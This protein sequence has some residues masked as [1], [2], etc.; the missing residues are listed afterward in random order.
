LPH[1]SIVPIVAQSCELLQVSWRYKKSSWSDTTVT[2]DKAEYIDQF[3]EEEGDVCAN[4]FFGIATT[5][6]SLQRIVLLLKQLNEN[7]TATNKANISTAHNNSIINI[8]AK[9]NR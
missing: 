7:W 4:E 9:I 8:T 1:L 5:C 2:W 3:E 6:Q